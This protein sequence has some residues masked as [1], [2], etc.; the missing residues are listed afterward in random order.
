MIDTSQRS[1]FN[2]LCR[3]NLVTLLTSAASPP[4]L[5]VGGLDSPPPPAPPPE[6]HFAQ[7]KEAKLE[8]GLRV[9]VAQRSSLPLLAAQFV[10]SNGSEADPPNLAGTASMTGALLSK[11][12]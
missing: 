6:T 1:T 11:G 3:C 4:A 12:T 2:V 10:L 9:I 8:N 5:A 7:P